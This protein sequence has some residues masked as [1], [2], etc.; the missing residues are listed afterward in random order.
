MVDE[1]MH[2]IQQH[3]EVKREGSVL[4]KGRKGLLIDAHVAPSDTESLDFPDEVVRSKQYSS[5]DAHG[6]TPGYAAQM[7]GRSESREY[8][9]VKPQAMPD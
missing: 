1:D 3:E 7:A 2:M 8:L 9:L 4:G 6:T 5:L